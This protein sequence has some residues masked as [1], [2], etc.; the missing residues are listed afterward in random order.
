MDSDAIEPVKAPSN[1]KPKDKINNITLKTRAEAQGPEMKIVTQAPKKE[2]PMKPENYV[3]RPEMLGETPDYVDC[4]YCK[5]RHKT[6]VRQK[7]SSQTQ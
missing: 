3:V 7:G 4:W 2:T 5:E 1:H 6:K